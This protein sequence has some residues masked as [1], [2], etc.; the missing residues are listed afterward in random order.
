[1]AAFNPTKNEGA[2]TASFSERPAVEALR[3]PQS[4]SVLRAGKYALHAHTM[5]TKNP[6]L[7]AP[8]LARFIRSMRNRGVV[9]NLEIADELRADKMGGLFVA[10]NTAM[11]RLSRMTRF[12]E[13]IDKE[14]LKERLSGSPVTPACL[15]SLVKSGHRAGFYTAAEMKEAI[16]CMERPLSQIPKLWLDRLT[17]K[18]PSGAGYFLEDHIEDVEICENDSN[19][20]FS[21]TTFAPSVMFYYLPEGDGEHD[22][23]IRDALES[24]F[25]AAGYLF[26][27]IVGSDTPYYCCI[28]DDLQYCREAV[29]RQTF[30]AS[31]LTDA[32]ENVDP[33]E[34]ECMTYVYTSTPSRWINAMALL[35]G[36]YSWLLEGRLPE[37]S[38]KEL[39]NAI[40]RQSEGMVGMLEARLNHQYPN[41]IKQAYH[42]VDLLKKQLSSSLVSQTDDTFIDHDPLEYSFV[43]QPFI[44]EGDD[45]NPVNAMMCDML[46]GHME[47][48]MNSGVEHG[49]SFILSKDG[50]DDQ[51]DEMMEYCNIMSLSSAACIALAEETKQFG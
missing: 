49:Q 48:I 22:V 32:L 38:G 2:L 41:L 6:L 23:L 24:V 1:M 11:K 16:S 26:G 17:K 20:I 18:M 33:D 44:S 34:D 39:A 50:S 10:A 8:S 45:E 30:T 35:S 19:A 36:R 40:V 43:F 3:L 28:L 46:D 12:T 4:S 29:G 21:M 27:F 7:D 47:M 9:S 14:A 31:D 37:G 13:H 42:V 51:T 25:A 15:P 5:Q